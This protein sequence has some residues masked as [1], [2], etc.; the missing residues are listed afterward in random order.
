MVFFLLRKEKKALKICE[1]KRRIRKLGEEV[2]EGEK[3]KEIRFGIYRLSF[4][5]KIKQKIK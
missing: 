1:R 4:S 5:P 3:M 2:G